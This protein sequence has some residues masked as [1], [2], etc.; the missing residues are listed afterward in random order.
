MTFVDQGVEYTCIRTG[1]GDSEVKSVVFGCGS[2]GLTKPLQLKRGGEIVATWNSD[3]VLEIRPKAQEFNCVADCALH[4]ILFHLGIMDDWLL[5]PPPHVG[6]EGM[7]ST[8]LIEEK[9][10][11]AAQAHEG[12][13][14]A[15]IDE[16]GGRR[17]V[18]KRKSD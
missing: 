14:G 12:L 18:A 9:E 8:E 3:G 13:G 11:S 1:K 15:I 6:D 17:V 2:C 4:A 5:S 10:E 7:A 16:K